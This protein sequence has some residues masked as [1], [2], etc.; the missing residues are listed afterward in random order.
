MKFFNIF[1][2]AILFSFK[3]IAAS[4]PKTSV[5]PVFDKS[6]LAGSDISGHIWYD[7][8]M[9]GI[10]DVSESP[11]S[12]IPVL[13]YTCNGIFH[14]SVLSQSDGSYSFT[15]IPDGNYKIFVSLAGIGNS[16]NYTFLS[17]TTDNKVNNTGFS[18]CFTTNMG[19]YILDGG[20]TV[21][22][23]LGDKVW[24]DLNGNGIQEVGEPGIPNVEVEVYNSSGLVTSTTTNS[25]GSYYFNTLFPGQYYL[26]F[27]VPSGYFS[28]LYI[29]GA[30]SNSDVTNVNGLYTTDYF[31]VD[32]QLDN[33]SLDGGFYK[34]AKICGIIYND[35]NYSD[36]LNTNENGINGLS[37]HLFEIAGADTIYYGTTNTGHKPGSPS[38]DGYYE[39]CVKPGVY[40]VEINS[41]NLTDYI[42]GLPFATDDPLTYNHFT[43]KGDS[44]VSYSITLQSGDSYCNINQGFYCVSTIQSIVW[45]DINHNGIREDSE[46][47]AEGVPAK[48]YNKNNTLIQTTISDDNGLAT[49][50]KVKKGIYY[51]VFDITPEYI[52]TLPYA[53]V[54][55]KDSDVD[56]SYGVGS[57]A[58][59]NIN[60][61]KTFTGIDAGIL[62]QPLPVTWI[63]VNVDK[64]PKSNKVV[65]KVAQEQ[66][67]SH[68]L[69][70]KSIDGKNWIVSDR[71]FPSE[72]VRNQFYES[73]DFQ[74]DAI[75]TFYRIESVDY[76]GNTSFSDIVYVERNSKNI[77]NIYPNP[78]NQILEISVLT[79][80]FNAEGLTSV[81]IDIF[82]STGQP[83]YT[84]CVLSEGITKI[85]V[86]KWPEGLYQVVLRNQQKVINVKKI[87]IIHK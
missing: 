23:Y 9:D 6:S 86:E 42:P 45:L 4:S 77:F 25:Y 83:V 48:L 53:G 51:I 49:F 17:S 27:N 81:Y 76:D 40:Y 16:Y 58:W 73:I 70:N 26:K 43:V 62:L 78:T 41:R 61:C 55:D 1:L 54:S 35:I 14:A 32:P 84:N 72:D 64:L 19:N 7:I 59:F 44:V 10:R 46:S 28:T 80:I 18:E 39:F 2:L 12:N 24:E 65:W 87:S 36:S 57:T 52:Y 29:A 13:L 75:Q 33:F 79:D 82:N 71:I 85:D 60:E 3:S 38:D 15:N 11:F 68:Y 74:I 50:K 8:N 5:T 22:P 56:G 34:C 67:L 63:S 69:V 31:T 20:I 37:I 47:R 21:F 66:N 30:P